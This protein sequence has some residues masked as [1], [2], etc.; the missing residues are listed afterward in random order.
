MGGRE[1]RIK[2]V[3]YARGICIILVVMM[4]ATLGVEAA[5]GH[6]GW[7]HAVVEFAKPFRIP[8]FFLLS[9]LFA[10]RA[11]HRDWRTFVD[12]KVLHFVYFYILWVTIQVGFKL[13]G[14]VIEHGFGAALRL[15]ALA[16]VDPFGSL[17]F[18]YMLPIFYL[19]TRLVAGVPW[20]VVW[21]AAAA[22]EIAPIETTWVVIDEF[23]GRFVYFYTGYLMTAR[24]FAF[25]EAAQSRP[26]LGVAAVTA[27]ALINLAAVFSGYAEFGLVSLALGFTG[28]AAIVF[29]TALAANYRAFPALEY[30]GRISLMIY[31]SFFLPIAATRALLIRSH[32]IA[33]VGTIAALTTLA[34]IFGA[35]AIYR[36]ARGTR[37]GFL[38]ERPAQARL[39]EPLRL[40]TQP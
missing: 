16:F 12:R 40:A 13:P 34:G 24:I 33:D 2:W 35:V 17:W 11:L 30:C 38:F 29:A 7:M 1:S 18:I 32:L 22:L 4:H 15:Y 6:E 9:G 19:T 31:L 37:F 14:Y 8:T 10:G 39:A 5:Y 25:A 23:A 21:L 27:W 20:W 36:L 28:A 3:D 26:V